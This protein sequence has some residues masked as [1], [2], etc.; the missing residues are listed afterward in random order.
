MD[1]IVE[2][3][4]EGVARLYFLDL[5]GWAKDLHAARESVCRVLSSLLEDY[6]IVFPRSRLQLSPKNRPLHGPTALYWA[7]IRTVR[8]RSKSRSPEMRR[9]PKHLKGF[10]PDW[11]F[12]KAKRSDRRDRLVDF[13]RRRLALNAASRA[14]MS[15]LD[16]LRRA[17][18]RRFTLISAAAG[19]KSCLD[20]YTLIEL[21]PPPVEFFPPGLPPRLSQ[22]LKSGW[23]AA[24]SLALAEDEVCDLALEVSRNPSVDGLRLDLSERKK[25]NL[26]RSTRWVVTPTG[27]TYPTLNNR[28][29]RK[30]HL[31]EGVRP[32]LSMKE[33]KRRRIEKALVRTAGTLDSIRKTCEAAQLVV[34][35]KLAE[36]KRILVPGT[37]SEMSATPRVAG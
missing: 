31:R 15:A 34:S 12:T 24:F 25:P 4:P 16:H 23:I 27:A 3:T 10:H 13:N 37:P 18:V 29:M 22:C 7:E 36:A 9:V 17:T 30:L 21:P 33:R 1:R 20:P 35:A 5:A 8:V 14:V 11:A 28:L 26:L 19:I 32:V 2:C 6:G